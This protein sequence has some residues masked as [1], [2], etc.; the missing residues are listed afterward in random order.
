[1]L[2]SGFKRL[3]AEAARPFKH[4]LWD[5]HEVTFAR[6]YWLKKVT[7]LAKIQLTFGLLIEE[8]PVEH[9]SREC[10]SSWGIVRMICPKPQVV[11]FCANAPSEL[12][13]SVSFWA[14]FMSYTF[15]FQTFAFLLPL[16]ISHM[17]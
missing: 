14:C 16:I 5:T 8:V 15:I 1:M 9:G 6:F 12:Y 17:P 13:V 7:R 3:R 2:V 10:D 4:R 11:Y